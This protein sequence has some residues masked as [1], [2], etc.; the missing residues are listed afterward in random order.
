MRKKYESFVYLLQ[1]KLMVPTYTI[2]Q[3]LLF[4]I[5]SSI[6]KGCWANT[7][8]QIILE[9]PAMEIGEKLLLRNLQ[10]RILTMIQLFPA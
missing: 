10:I 6:E 1:V 2:L 9:H 7:S 4:I 3:S 5:H 8:F